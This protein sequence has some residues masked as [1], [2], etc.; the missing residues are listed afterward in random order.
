MLPDLLLNLCKTSF[1]MEVWGRGV[2]DRFR[3]YNG[4]CNNISVQYI[5]TVSFIG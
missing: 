5:V 4:T 1:F 2:S 3:V